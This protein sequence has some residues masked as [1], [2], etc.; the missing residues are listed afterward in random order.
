M[1]RGSTME[2]KKVRDLMVKTEDFPSVSQEA[3]FLEALDAL[4]AAQEAFSSGKAKQRIVLV[5]DGAGNVVGKI[6]PIDLSRGLEPGYK[7]LDQRLKGFIRFGVGYLIKPLKEQYWLWAQPFEDLCRKALNVRVMEFM[8]TPDEN[9]VVGPNDS[10]AE[11][12]HLFVTASHDSLFVVEG[13]RIIGLL[14]F[15]DLYRMISGLMKSC[16]GR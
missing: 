2:D 9:R 15:S 4:E 13:G 8:S 7:E 1:G 3:T 12:L 14:R 16:K 5:K 11:A 10:L 6:S